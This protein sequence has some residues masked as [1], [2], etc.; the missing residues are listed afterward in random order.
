MR[1]LDNYLIAL[2]TTVQD[3]GIPLR[4]DGWPAVSTRGSG[5]AFHLGRFVYHAAHV[6]CVQSN[7]LRAL[8]AVAPM[9]NGEC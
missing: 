7:E 8:S 6:H 9:I 3:L 2:A 4:D 5:V 1:Q